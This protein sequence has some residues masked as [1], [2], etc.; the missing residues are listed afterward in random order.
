[1]KIQKFLY[2]K[3]TVTCT[4]TFYQWGN[5]DAEKLGCWPIIQIKFQANIKFSVYLECAPILGL[6]DL[7]FPVVV[8]L[9]LSQINFV[10]HLWFVLS[11][12]YILWFWNVR[13][14][15]CFF[16]PTQFYECIILLEMLFLWFN[17]TEILPQSVI[18]QWATLAWASWQSFSLASSVLDNLLSVM[19]IW[20]DK[21]LKWI[22]PKM[23]NSGKLSFIL[24][25]FFL[26]PTAET[27]LPTLW[28]ASMR[29]DIMA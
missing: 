1:M 15:Y 25:F 3:Q 5:T 10:N 27:S 20:W 16:R 7:S 19:I 26:F 23:K 22:L 13:R 28:S 6:Y 17:E 9:S 8:N 18:T 14:K 12:G 21:L 2:T 4:L 29:T 24:N 11:F